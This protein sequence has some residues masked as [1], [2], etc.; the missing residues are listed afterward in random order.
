MTPKY[1]HF[2]S[3][4]ARFTDDE[5][6]VC[7]HDN[8]WRTAATAAWCTATAAVPA[9]LLGWDLRLIQPAK[10]N[11]GVDALTIG[12]ALPVH[13]TPLVSLKAVYVF[14]GLDRKSESDFAGAVEK[15]K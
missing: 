5:A 14:H 2:E 11:Y 6:W 8:V 7:Q 10:A 13:W 4:P 15:L 12:F 1:G 3:N 9:E